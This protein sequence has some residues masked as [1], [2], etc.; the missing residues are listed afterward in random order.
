MSCEM[1]L[2]CPLAFTSGHE[3]GF[4]L[5]IPMGKL[6]EKTK[7][8]K[9]FEDRRKEE[10]AVRLA[11][12]KAKKRAKKTSV[13]GPKRKPADTLLHYI[14]SVLVPHVHVRSL[15]TFRCN[16]YSL[17]KQIRALVDHLFVTY[18]VPE[19]LYPCMYSSA[20]K[21]EVLRQKKVD[22]SS[23]QKRMVTLFEQTLFIAC[24]S[25]YSL[26]PIL[27][28]RL[29]KKEVHVFL[30]GH[31]GWTAR[32]NMLWAKLKVA[33][34]RQ[35]WI[36]HLVVQFYSS[37]WARGLGSAFVA[38]FCR[39]FANSKY[40]LSDRQFRSL[41]DYLAQAEKESE[42]TLK[43][44]T[45]ESLFKASIE[46]HKRNVW[47]HV[48]V[49]ESWAGRFSL[50]TSVHFGLQ[51]RVLELT[52]S[53]ALHDESYEQDHCVFTYLHQCKSGFSRI[54][55][56]RWYQMQGGNAA[57]IVNRITIEVAPSSNQIVQIRGK[58]NRVATKQEMEIIRTW[59][60]EHGVTI[61]KSAK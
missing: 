5:F 39:I 24:A 51:V 54:L 41:V 20:G 60:G 22:A 2:L 48:T 10:L 40:R 28:P 34:V 33:G 44:R 58:H 16:A 7:L 11:L 53:R 14:E 21:V 17:D 50:W 37:L 59:A 52:N 4:G 8:Q 56:V 27:K 12:K 31:A 30:Q 45:L 38:D 1:G 46:W 6:K 42:Y 23:K 57:V 32:Q 15:D 18:R 9:K 55:S 35:E 25:G 3:Y 61:S 26:V 43:G 47:G 36:D 13:S 29:T 49:Y 19:F